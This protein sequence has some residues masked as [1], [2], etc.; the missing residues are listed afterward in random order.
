M[1]FASV[2]AASMRTAK[3]RFILSAAIVQDIQILCVQIAH[4]TDFSVNALTFTE[5]CAKL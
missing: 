1:P 4:N 2:R 5:F 3:A